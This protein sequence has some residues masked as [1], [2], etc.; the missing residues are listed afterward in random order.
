VYFRRGDVVELNSGGPRMIVDEI[1]DDAGSV[2][3]CKWYEGRE[4]QVRRFFV[5]GLRHAQVA[6]GS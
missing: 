3:V 6:A 2:L 1:E 4:K 5:D